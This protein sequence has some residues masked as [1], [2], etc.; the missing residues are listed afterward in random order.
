[1]YLVRESKPHRDPNKLRPEERLKVLFGKRH[2]EA[3]SVDYDLITEA[4]QV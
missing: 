3:L 4:S 2:F 1:M